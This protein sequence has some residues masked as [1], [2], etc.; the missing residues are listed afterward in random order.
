LPGGVAE[1][2]SA[3]QTSRL[4]ELDVDLAEQREAG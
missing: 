2:V 1:L 4:Q 3:H